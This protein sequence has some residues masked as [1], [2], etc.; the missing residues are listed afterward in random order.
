MPLLGFKSDVCDA[1]KSGNLREL[2]TA[3]AS[4]PHLLDT[5]HAQQRGRTPLHIAAE[6]GHAGII[7]KLVELGSQAIDTPDKY[8]CTPIS[9]AALKGR[10]SV[11][12]TLVR[13]GSQAIDICLRPAVRP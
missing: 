2:V 4:Y 5:P 11:I 8:G 6:N 9:M 7:A 10:E 13:L 1:A 12:E 3:L